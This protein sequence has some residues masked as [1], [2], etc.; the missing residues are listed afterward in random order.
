MVRF[1]EALAYT[2]GFGVGFTLPPAF[3]YQQYL[4]VKDTAV[5]DSESPVDRIQDVLNGTVIN[6]VG[7]VLSGPVFAYQ[8]LAL[9]EGLARNNK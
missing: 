7:A 6:F 9:K 4:L 3:A 2:Y 8:A 5:T 1:L